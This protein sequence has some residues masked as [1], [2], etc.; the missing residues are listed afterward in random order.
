MD[1]KVLKVFRNEKNDNDYNL[2]IY[3]EGGGIELIDSSDTSDPSLWAKTANSYKTTG[4]I[5]QTVCDLEDY[6]NL[7]IIT[8]D[9][10]TT[11]LYGFSR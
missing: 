10:G 9:N 8:N 4:E 1:K 3:I 11:N 5:L 2:G 6:R 7:Y